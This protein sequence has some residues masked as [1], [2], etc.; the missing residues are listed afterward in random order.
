MLPPT[1]RQIKV[2]IDMKGTTATS[3]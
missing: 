2:Y 1:G 3:C